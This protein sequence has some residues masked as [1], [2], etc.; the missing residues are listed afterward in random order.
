MNKELT[1]NLC[2]SF[3]S[4]RAVHLKVMELKVPLVAVLQKDI[5]YF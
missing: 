3:S 5:D 4:L 1:M 2:L